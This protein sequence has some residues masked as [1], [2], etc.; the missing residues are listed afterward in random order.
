MSKLNSGTVA[1]RLIE[2]SGDLF[3]VITREGYI[4][5]LSKEWEVI[6]GR[7]ISELRG[8][9]FISFI[10]EKDRPA[11]QAALDA[12]IAGADLKEF[13]HSYLRTDGTPVLFECRAVLDEETDLVFAA[14]TPVTSTQ[15]L[16]ELQ[17][18]DKEK[19]IQASKLASLGEMAAGIAHEV[20][21]PLSIIAG[22]LKILEI[23]WNQGQMK[24]AEFERILS[25]LNASTERAAKIINNLK[26]LAR[27]GANDPF[28]RAYVREIVESSLDL[29]RERFKR[30]GVGLET[31]YEGEL[32]ID[33]R[34]VEI[35]QVLLNL[36]INA[37][38]AVEGQTSAWV[39]VSYHDDL[40]GHAVIRVSNSG[41]VISHQVKDKIF[42]PFFTTKL[43]GK[44]TGLGLSIAATIIRHHEGEIYLDEKSFYTTFV[45][46]LP[47]SRAGTGS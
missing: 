38:D 14:G 29:V 5:A 2:L 18:L 45:I 7:T 30:H 16:L 10:L 21:N 17:E 32:W 13:R 3:F 47:L 1:Q 42:N 4:F 43:P 26:N 15:Q 27:D 25:A 44:G 22:Y 33:C 12:V 19:S 39:K 6:L 46:R 35:S 40:A 23:E 31:A 34:A 36:F 24:P 8:A 20:N 11:T 9:P 41:T 37:F 28:E